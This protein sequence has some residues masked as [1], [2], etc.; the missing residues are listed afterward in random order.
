MPIAV[1]LNTKKCSAKKKKIN[2]HF[3]HFFHIFAALVYS[4]CHQIVIISYKYF[5]IVVILNILSNE[6]RN[7]VFDS[8][9]YSCKETREKGPQLL[10]H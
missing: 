5:A 4:T 6:Q 7:T 10:P 2:E 9:P 8:G 3:V 1:Y